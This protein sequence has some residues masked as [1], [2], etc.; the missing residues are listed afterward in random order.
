MNAGSGRRYDALTITLN[1]AIDRTVT[2]PDFAAGKVNR[3]EKV[4]QNPG[5]KGVNVAVTLADADHAVAAT[6]FL[7]RENDAAFEQL[8]ARKRIDD[9]FVRI[10]GQTRVGIKIVDPSLQQTTDINFPGLSPSAADR[11]ALLSRLE[12]ID[13]TWVVLAGSLPPSVDD[14]IYRDLIAALAS[15]GCT[16]A[17]DTSGEP[18]RLALEAAPRIV[19]PN[20]HELEALLGEPLPTRAAVVTAARELLARGVGLVVV[21]MGADGAL[22][23]SPGEVLLARP[24]RV[25]VRSTVGAGDAMVAG[26]VSAHLRG[27]PLAGA[28][29]LATAFSVDAISRIGAGL[30]GL[31]SVGAIAERVAVEEL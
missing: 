10:A 9:Q 28:A 27:L 18:L 4:E 17:L 13:A 7:G 11:D 1:P 6:G 26:I 16:V 20:I 19:K 8:F 22:F 31:E 24:P 23:V 21:S 29:R 30:S 25:T 15:R 14:A 3:V 2:I 5:G 12:A